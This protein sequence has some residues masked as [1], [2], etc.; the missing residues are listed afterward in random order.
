[1]GDTNGSLASNDKPLIVTSISELNEGYSRELLFS[2]S[3]DEQEIINNDI[4][5]IIKLFS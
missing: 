3:F 5:V 4:T 2:L 1:M